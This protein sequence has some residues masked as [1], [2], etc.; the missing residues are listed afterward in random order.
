MTFEQLLD[1]LSDLHPDIDF[2]TAEGL[3]DRK[4]LT[5]FDVVSIAAEL[6]ET[7]GVELRA[8]DIVPANFNSA[9]ALFAL[10]QKRED[11]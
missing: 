7:Y 11:E 2:E 1:L 5:S 10:I 3:I 4:V 8:V 9:R 6:S